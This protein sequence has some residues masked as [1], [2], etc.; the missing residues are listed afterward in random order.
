MEAFS[1]RSRSNIQEIP[2][3]LWHR[4]STPNSPLFGPILRQLN[5]FHTEITQFLRRVLMLFSNLPL[6]FNVL[7]NIVI[8]F[9]YLTCM[10]YY[11]SVPLF[12]ISSRV[13]D[14]S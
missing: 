8:N 13:Q 1:L 9:S 3:V 14:I 2:C 7:D 11:L 12:L 5:T 6:P 4:K 10:L